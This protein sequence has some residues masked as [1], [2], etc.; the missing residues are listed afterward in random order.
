M[1]TIVTT[2]A[3]PIPAVRMLLHQKFIKILTICMS[4]YKPIFHH[5]RGPQKH[6]WVGVGVAIRLLALKHYT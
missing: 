3:N 2:I 5:N 1:M 4:D 6:S